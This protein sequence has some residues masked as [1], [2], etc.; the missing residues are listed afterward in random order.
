MPYHGIL[1]F[2]PTGAACPRVPLPLSPLHQLQPKL[3]DHAFPLNS[4]NDKQGAEN[5]PTSI[6]PLM[7]QSQALQRLFRNGVL[8]CP[9][10]RGGDGALLVLLPALGNVGGERV[11]RV[12]G[13]EKRLDRQKNGSDL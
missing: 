10:L 9:R 3:V 5:Y 2:P 4:S 1:L 12:G 6:S 13:T 8:M 11:V 7:S